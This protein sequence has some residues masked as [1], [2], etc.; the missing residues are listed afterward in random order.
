M[1]ETLDRT[2]ASHK[3]AW[4]VHSD[5]IGGEVVE[6]GG[7]L[8]CFNGVPRAEFNPTFALTDGFSGALPALEKEYS[9]RGIPFGFLADQRFQAEAAEAATRLGLHA[10][11]PAPSMALHPVGDLLAAAAD[12]RLVT[13]A[14]ALE[15]HLQVQV[16][17]FG[18]DPEVLR[19]FNPP[20]V[21]ESE[22]RYY[23]AYDGGI[24]AATATSV[25]TGRDAGIFA[26]ATH[27]EH[28]RRGLARAVTVAAI[29]AAVAAGCDLVYLQSTEMGYPVYTDLGFR[30]VEQYR[31]F[32]RD[33]SQHEA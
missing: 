17:G 29:R 18:S 13:T 12:V 11:N 9:S 6:R 23:L 1:S 5:A 20:S 4:L 32:V 14:D 19:A 31:T 10:N 27:P 33:P 15:E 7:L 8:T 16:A 22:E 2:R 28:R 25:V 3:A 30:T 21:L 26:V 24:P